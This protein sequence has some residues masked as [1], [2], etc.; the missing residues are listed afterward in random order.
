MSDWESKARCLGHETNIWF[1][2]PDGPDPL[3][4]K[5]KAICARC[6]VAVACLNFAVRQRITVGI[7]GGVNEQRRTRLRAVLLNGSAL[8]YDEALDTAIQRTRDEVN[9]VAPPEQDAGI[10][11]RCGDVIDPGPRPEDRN[12]PNATCGL[13]ATYNKGCRC[14]SCKQAKAAHQSKAKKPTPDLSGAGAILTAPDG[15]RPSKS[16]GKNSMTTDTK[17]AAKKATKKPAAK[18]ADVADLDA[19]RAESNGQLV[20]EPLPLDE[21]F[22]DDGLDLE[23]L[24]ADA[25]PE[26]AEWSKLGDN[27][28]RADMGGPWWLGD[29][30][31]WGQEHF[32]EEQLAAAIDPLRVTASTLSNKA[33]VA[34][35]IP[36]EERRVTTVDWSLHRLAAELPTIPQIREALHIAEVDGLTY[37]EMDKLVRKMKGGDDE[38]D[39]PDPAKKTTVSHTITFTVALADKKGAA[40]VAGKLEDF[41]RAELAERSIEP[42]KITASEK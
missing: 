11:Q 26:Y 6:P 9:G 25:V 35:K 22:A 15:I 10:C 16:G 3:G 37:R 38:A 33:W 36:R 23:L 14:R 20:Q 29:W 31:R 27:V 21:F 12:G 2:T 5:A 17:K 7:Y 19:K 42:T 8:E 34:T 39:A 40:S 18:K 30:Y 4:A 24:G 32:T 13:A 28:T 1:P 41:I